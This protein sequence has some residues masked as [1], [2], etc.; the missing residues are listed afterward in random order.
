MSNRLGNGYSLFLALLLPLQVRTAFEFDTE[1]LRVAVSAWCQDEASA[2]ATYGHI[3]AWDTSRVKSFRGLFMLAA[4][5]GHCSTAATF[6]AD[7]SNWD[8]KLFSRILKSRETLA[9]SLFF[10][11]AFLSLCY[12]VVC[13][14]C[15]PRHGHQS[16]PAK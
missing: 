8:G 5:E 14:V 3:S 2:E 15:P 1:T 4:W 11:S 12:D 9:Y 7:I 10:S 13:F 6:N 16:Q